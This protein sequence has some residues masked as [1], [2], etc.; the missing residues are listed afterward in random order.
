MPEYAI[1]KKIFCYVSFEIENMAKFTL[2][3]PPSQILK[4]NKD[5]LYLNNQDTVI[6]S[7]KIF[8]LFP[9]KIYTVY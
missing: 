2:L 4:L 9:D 8:S 6:N 3:T 5:I 1:K 7:I